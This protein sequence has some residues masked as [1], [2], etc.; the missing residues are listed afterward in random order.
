[1]RRQ[2]WLKINVS[3]T[4]FGGPDKN[5]EAMLAEDKCVPDA[6]RR[7]WLQRILLP[8]DTDIFFLLYNNVQHMKMIDTSN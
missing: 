5:E 4:Q 3:L 6:V 1:M 8:N 2:C 7:P